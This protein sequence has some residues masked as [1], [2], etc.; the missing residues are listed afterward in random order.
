MNLSDNQV[1]VLMRNLI[2]ARQFDEMMVRRM[3]QGR[4]IGFYHPAEGHLAPGVGDAVLIRLGHAV[5][6]PGVIA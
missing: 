1:N 4:L 6:P 2:R 5:P 3:M